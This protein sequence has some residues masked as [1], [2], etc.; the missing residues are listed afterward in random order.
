MDA[1]KHIFI[2]CSNGYIDKVFNVI[3]CYFNNYLSKQIKICKVFCHANINIDPM[4]DDDF[5]RS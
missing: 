2:A 4:K 3:R 1:N 5:K